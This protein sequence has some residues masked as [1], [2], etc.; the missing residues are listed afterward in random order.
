MTSALDL[1]PETARLG[2][3]SLLRTL[4]PELVAL[5]LDAKQAH[6]NLKGPNFLALH[7]VTDALADDARAWTDRVAERAVALGLAVDARPAAVARVGTELPGGHVLDHE[8]VA[9]LS[10]ALARVASAARGL[11]DQL[12]HTDAVAHDIAVEVVEG[13]DK[14]RW[15]FQAQAF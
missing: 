14:Y 13:A 7:A 10:V 5:T 2:A 6:W 1:T 11:L 9:M 15:M 8:V 12:D 3:A 4:V